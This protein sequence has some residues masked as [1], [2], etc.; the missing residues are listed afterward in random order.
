MKYFDYFDGAF[1]I[2][3]ATRLDR[4]ESFEKKAG[5]AGLV[6]PRFNAVSFSPSDVL[7]RED[8]PNWHKKISSATS[9]MHCIQLAKDNC[10]ENCLI[11]EDDCIFID[12]FE[13]KAQACVNDLK[14]RDWDMFFFGGEPA[15]PCEPETQNIVRTDGVYGAH[16]YAINRKFYDTVLGY[17]SDRNL[18]DII[19]IHHARQNKAYYLAKELL[20]WQ[21]DD[22]YPSDLWIKSGSENIY[23]EAYKKY[24]P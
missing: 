11:F 2:N 12:D 5:A 13:T 6:V 7:Q 22:R 15:G 14:T 10:W 23:R 4:R 16:A 17:P 19:F 1:Y 18:I 9:H 8:D 3:L 20:I 21:D 24:V